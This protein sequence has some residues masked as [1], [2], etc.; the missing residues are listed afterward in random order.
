MMGKLSGKVL[1]LLL[2]IA[3]TATLAYAAESDRVTV[4][5]PAT[6][7]VMFKVTSAGNVKG[8]S[9]SVLDSNGVQQVV[10]NPGAV[11]IGV[12]AP[13]RPLVVDSSSNTL[14]AGNSSVIVQGDSNKERLEMRSFNVTPTPSFMGM[15]AQGTKASPLPVITD[16][17]LF[18]LGGFGWNGTAYGGTNPAGNSAAAAIGLNAAETHTTTHKGSYIFFAT[19]QNATTARTERVRIADTGNVG[20]GTNSPTQLLDVNGSGIRIRTPNTPATSTSPCNQG[21]MAWDA[22]YIYVCVATNSWKRSGLASW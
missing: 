6:G 1:L 19:T 9:F 22:S 2:A 13:D 14:A 3:S 8:A 4:E 7:T 20:I 10:A 21:E 18:F 12:A 15:S 11:G 16:N 17:Y 5:D